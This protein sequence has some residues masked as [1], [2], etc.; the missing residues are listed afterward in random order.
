MGGN[1]LTWEQSA[2]WGP[3]DL[4]G[5]PA[6]CWRMISP[7][8]PF[9]SSAASVLGR[10]LSLLEGRGLGTAKPNPRAPFHRMV[11]GFR[12][13]SPALALSC[14][15]KWPVPGWWFSFSARESCYSALRWLCGFFGWVGV[16]FCLKHELV[17]LPFSDQLG[18]VFWGWGSWSLLRWGQ[19]HSIVCCEYLEIKKHVKLRFFFLLL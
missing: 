13:S 5:L 4:Q 14:A 17:F 2:L 15:V 18:N 8:N 16:F 7:R 11:W 12:P 6:W 10:T 19:L 9:P 3:A 1:L